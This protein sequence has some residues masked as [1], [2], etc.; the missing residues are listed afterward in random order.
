MDLALRIE[1]CYMMLLETAF[2]FFLDAVDAAANLVLDF[3]TGQ[4]EGHYYLILC[5]SSETTM[6]HWVSH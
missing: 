6:W 3:S 2:D 5:Q 4:R 1:A